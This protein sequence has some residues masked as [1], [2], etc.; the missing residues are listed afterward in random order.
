MKART[1]AALV[2]AL[3]GALIGAVL[4]L[5]FGGQGA[6]YVVV[7]RCASED[8]TGCLWEADKQGNGV[9][10]SFYAPAQGKGR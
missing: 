10:Q 2:W 4:V 1:Q 5:N 8:S 3:V 6:G 9:G 7:E